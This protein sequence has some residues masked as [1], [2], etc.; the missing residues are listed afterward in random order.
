MYLMSFGPQ[1]NVCGL[2]VLVSVV[3]FQERAVDEEVLDRVFIIDE[4]GVGETRQDLHTPQ[5]CITIP[6]LTI[7]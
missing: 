2:V 6:V 3:C 1:N 4:A 5:S 7:K